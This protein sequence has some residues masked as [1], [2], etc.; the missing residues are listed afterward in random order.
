M[1]VYQSSCIYVYMF[2][3]VRCVSVYVCVCWGVCVDV[4]VCWVII[5]KAP[6]AT[7]LFRIVLSVTDPMKRKVFRQRRDTGDIYLEELYS[8]L[9][10]ECHSRVR[11]PLQQ[12]SGAGIKKYAT[13]EQEHQIDQQSEVVCEDEEERQT[14]DVRSYGR[15]FLL[16]GLRTATTKEG[17]VE[18]RMQLSIR[19]PRDSRPKGKAES[20][21]VK[22]SHVK[23]DARFIRLS[24]QCGI[25]INA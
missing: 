14:K 24:K 1:C 8:G 23:S 11:D 17:A 3:Y 25:G 22:S 10:G 13:R 5:S 16:D 12:T 6:L 15:G 20:Q 9:N 7:R 4:C 19:L 18:V 21:V 2:I